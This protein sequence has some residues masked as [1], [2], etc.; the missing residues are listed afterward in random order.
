MHRGVSLLVNRRYYRAARATEIRHFGQQRLGSVSSGAPLAVA[1][2]IHS[3]ASA[4]IAALAVTAFVSVVRPA[5]A[6]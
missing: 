2:A 6:A 4:A 3:I 5:E 1:D